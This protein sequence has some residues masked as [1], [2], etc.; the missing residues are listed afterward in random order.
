MKKIIALLLILLMLPGMSAAVSAADIT[1]TNTG[2]GQDVTASYEAGA[3]NTTVISVDI[4]WDN[5]SFTYKGES[6]PVW[7]AAK[8]QYTGE[9]TEA[10]WV[11]SEASITI[12]NHSNAILQAGITYAPEASFSGIS[13]HFTDAA[14]YIGSA[15]TSDT[16]EGTPCSVT[17]LAVPDGILSSDTA[18][19][20][21]I[22]TITVKVNADIH[23]QTVLAAIEEQASIVSGRNADEIGRGTAYFESPKVADDILALQVTTMGVV[24]SND[25]T[26]AEKNAALNELITA[27]YGALKI[28]Q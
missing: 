28:K 18:A 2:N 15:D 1:D 14:P 27:Y 22:G 9:N 25:K 12:T 13:M 20:T 11:A 26:D 4:E 3:V 10:G 5:M 17:V 16:E 7:D 21:K 24:Y 23:A 6:E 19:N 8:H